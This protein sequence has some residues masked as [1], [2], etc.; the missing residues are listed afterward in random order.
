MKL[1]PVSALL[2]L[3]L[4]ACAHD[5]QIGE[6][7]RLLKSQGFVNMLVILLAIGSRS[8]REID[9]IFSARSGFILL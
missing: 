1:K 8:S 4:A 7:Q 2:S 6:Y 3:A 5:P 9:V